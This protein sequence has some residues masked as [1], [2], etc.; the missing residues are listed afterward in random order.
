MIYKKTSLLVSQLGYASS[1][2]CEKKY[3]GQTYQHRRENEDHVAAAPMAQKNVFS[4]YELVMT[5][6]HG[7]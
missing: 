5:I 3:D 2:Q 6:P 4:Q 1:L 7:L